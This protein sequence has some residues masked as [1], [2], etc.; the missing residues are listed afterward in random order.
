MGIPPWSPFRLDAA[1]QLQVVTQ[2][3]IA[4]EGPSIPLLASQS[5]RCSGRTRTEQ[6]TTA[7]GPEDSHMLLA[8]NVV[9]VANEKPPFMYIYASG[10]LGVAIASSVTLTT[11]ARIYTVTIHLQIDLNPGHTPKTFDLETTVQPRNRRQA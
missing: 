6:S 10:S 4:G 1:K 7:I 9:N 5:T 8:S 2:V 3:D 11:T